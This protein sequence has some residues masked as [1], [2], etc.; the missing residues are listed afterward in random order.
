[1]TSAKDAHLKSAHPKD[2]HPR[3]IAIRR[4]YDAATPTDGYR[5]LVD[6]FWPRGRSKADLHLDEW[7]RD[8]APTPELIR[9]FGHESQRWEEFRRRYLEELAAPGMRE[10]L[11]ALLAASGSQKITLVYGARNELENQAVV[12]RDVLLAM[13]RQK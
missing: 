3:V 6:H 8:V 7:A 4:A 2:A 9:W 5:V 12:L 11:E 13:T 1:M 10:K